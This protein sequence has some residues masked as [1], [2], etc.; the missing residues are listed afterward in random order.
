MTVA[1]PILSACGHETCILPSAVL[2]TH[3]GGFSGPTFRD[4]TEDLPAIR[5]HWE[6]EK[7]NFDAIY[8]GYLGST[9]QIGYV[10]DI[11]RSLSRPGSLTFVDPAMADHGKLYA[12]FDDDYVETMKSLC[13]QA[14][15]VL[16]NL[17]E[18]CMLTGSAYRES[19]DEVYICEI[20]KKLHT[21][22][23]PKVVLTGVSYSRGQTGVL[24]SDGKNQFL[25]RH[26][27]LPKNY[28]GT[29]D[30]FASAFVGAMLSG[31][32]MA[33]AAQIAADFVCRSIENTIG[34]DSHWYGVKFER[35]LPQLIRSLDK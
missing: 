30:C 10:C 12:G 7:I 18:A 15:V 24:V 2:S 8:T 1:M 14:D 4:L 32:A 9:K 31:A 34:D 22:G 27:K 28:H 23:I 5:Q 21:M 13:V 29:G 35:A 33:E 16:P 17:T 11:L 6:R 19:Y 20:V 3:T 25:Y 26:K